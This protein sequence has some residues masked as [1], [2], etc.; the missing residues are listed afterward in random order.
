MLTKYIIQPYGKLPLLWHPN[1]S[2]RSFSVIYPVL[3]SS[4]SS[5][6]YWYQSAVHVAFNGVGNIGLRLIPVLHASLSRG[7][8]PEEGIR[9]VFLDQRNQSFHYIYIYVDIYRYI[10]IDMNIYHRSST[11]CI[12]M[13]W[14][15]KAPIQYT[16]CQ[17]QQISDSAL[18]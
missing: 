9:S 7:S 6:P 2:T 16:W 18:Y 12:Q 1:Y 17:H 14:N 13:G 10:N 8:T 3:K 11:W 5:Y 15:S 4:Y